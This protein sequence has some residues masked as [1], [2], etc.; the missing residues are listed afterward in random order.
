[1]SLKDSR[2]VNKLNIIKAKVQTFKFV[3]YLCGDD[4]SFLINKYLSTVDEMPNFG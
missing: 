2:A 4:W 1:M 3:F